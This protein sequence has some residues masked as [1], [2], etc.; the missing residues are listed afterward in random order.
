MVLLR[1]GTVVRIALPDAT[2]LASRRVGPPAYSG[3]EAG[4]FLA[5][6]AG[7]VYVLDP[8]SQ[9]SL[10]ALDR[11]TLTVLWQRQLDLDVRYRGVVL[12]GGRLYA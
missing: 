6:R 11:R 10:S 9:P 4:R 5:P 12:A 2:V 8:A 1:N 7:A 3:V